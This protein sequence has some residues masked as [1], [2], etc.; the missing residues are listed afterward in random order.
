MNTKGA[1]DLNVGSLLSRLSLPP[2]TKV[3][4][5]LYKA[6]ESKKLDPQSVPGLQ[7]NRQ[8]HLVDQPE[9]PKGGG[10]RALRWIVGIEHHLEK[11][12]SS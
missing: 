5:K 2:P 1:W 3:S 9:T 7:R 12:W 11:P 6:S 4:P 8:P 10:A